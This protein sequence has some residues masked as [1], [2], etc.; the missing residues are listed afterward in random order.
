M[1]IE[2]NHAPAQSRDSNSLRST[3]TQEFLGLRMQNFQGVFLIST[4]TYGEILK[5]TLVYF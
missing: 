5:S 2:K 4:Q 3:L 1:E